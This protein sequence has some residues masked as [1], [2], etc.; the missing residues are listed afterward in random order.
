MF[1]QTTDILNIDCSEAITE[2]S[3]LLSY[4]YM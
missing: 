3:S 4:L 2:L 1:K